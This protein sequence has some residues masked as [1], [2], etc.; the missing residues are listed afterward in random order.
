MNNEELV[1]FDLERF[2]AGEQ[3]FIDGAYS[4]STEYL[5]ADWATPL[6]IRW[7]SGDETMYPVNYALKRIKMR[8]PKPTFE[9]F[10]AEKC[11]FWPCDLSKRTIADLAVEYYKQ[12]GALKFDG[13]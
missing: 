2:K 1:P 8:P 11:Q 13:E 7:D 12:H 4:L 10:C 5:G 9:A 3:V 6:V